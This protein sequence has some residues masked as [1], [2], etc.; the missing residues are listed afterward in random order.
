MKILLLEDNSED[1]EII[2]RLLKKAKPGCL[3]NLATGRTSFVSA[4]EQ[5]QPDVILSDNH[6]PQFSAPEALQIV[7]DRGLSIPFI[8]VTGTVSDEF[9]ANIIKAG[10]DDY[11]LKD[12]LTRLPSAIDAALKHRELEKEKKQALERLIESEDKYRTLFLKSPLPKW[13]Y[14]FDTLRFL[15]VNEAAI[16][17]YGYSFEEFLNMTIKEIRP[18]EDLQTLYEDL[19]DV[20]DKTDARSGVWRHLKKNGELILVETTAHFIKYKS[21]KARMVVAH[22]ITERTEA[23]RLR[24]FNRNNLS[25]LINNTDDLIWSVDKDL[26]LITSNDSFNKTVGRIYGKTLPQGSH[27]LSFPFSEDRLHRYQEYYK[28]AIAGESF[29]VVEQFNDPFPTWSELSFYPILQ[30]NSV[31]GTACF[32]RDITER[33]AAEEEL[34]SMENELLNQKIEAQKKVT[35]AIIKAQEKEREHI[36][37][38]L[39]DNVNQ[40]LASARMFLSMKDARNGELAEKFEYPRQLIDN[41]IEEIRSLT[42]GYVAPIKDINLKELIQLLLDKLDGN[43][44]LQT[45]L[46]FEPAQDPLNDELKLNIYRIVQ[47]QINNILK[48]ADAKKVT[49]GINTENGFINLRVV[50]DGKGFDPDRQRK[51]IG[52]SNMFHRV[53]SFNGEIT[54]ESA[55]GKG[56]KTTIRIPY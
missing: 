29:T 43:S 20:K 35:R 19:A 23:E 44:T 55:P 47:E 1:A 2:Q 26:K 16:K 49:V 7:Q 33:K 17:H 3:M 31:I 27:I 10:A 4:L 54:I 56:C 37:R 14:D 24:E 48:H 34:R 28:R 42:S 51:G 6:L 15:E 36:G 32:A 11:I 38:E 52:I 30:R 40:I 13:I 8:L 46:V 53:E 45:S 22:D 25:A 18:K 5:W 12:R 41:A 50:D 39:H 9:A 21:R